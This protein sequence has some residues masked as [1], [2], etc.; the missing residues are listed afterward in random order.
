MRALAFI[1]LSLLLVLSASAQLTQPPPLGLHEFSDITVTADT[2]NSFP[3]GARVVSRNYTIQAPYP[4][5]L[6]AI[7]YR[8]A[9]VNTST[10]AGVA[11]DVVVG[12]ISTLFDAAIG[13]GYYG[14]R[15]GVAV[16][17]ANG[18][19]VRIAEFFVRCIPTPP[20]RL[21][22]SLKLLGRSYRAS[23]T[24]SSGSTRTVT[25]SWT[26]LTTRFSVATISLQ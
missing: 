8:L 23:S 10:S 11:L 24:S 25:T 6:R 20:T 7:G 12:A 9:V 21:S 22:A 2:S 17:P 18:D 15:A 26:S 13:V 3:D 1:A 16:N 19:V 4:N 5:V 14:F